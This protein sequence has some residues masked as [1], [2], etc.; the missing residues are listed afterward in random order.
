MREPLY[1]AAVN[2]HVQV[3]ACSHCLEIENGDQMLLVRLT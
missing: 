2:T 1:E 3:T